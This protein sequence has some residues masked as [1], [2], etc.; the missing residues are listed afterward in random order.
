ML[1]HVIGNFF[2][3][4]VNI[5]GLKLPAIQPIVLHLCPTCWNALLGFVTKLTI[6]ESNIFKCFGIR[7]DIVGH[8]IS[9]NLWERRMVFVSRP[10]SRTSRSLQKGF[11]INMVV[12]TS[13][14]LTFVKW[15]KEPQNKACRSGTALPFVW[16]TST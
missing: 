12:K 15:I 5:I 4:G 1:V 3:K 8:K 13:L 11:E 16:K 2:D 14:I 9:G 10:T 7:I 6:G